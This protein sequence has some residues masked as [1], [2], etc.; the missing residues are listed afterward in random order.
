[1]TCTQ[2]MAKELERMEEQ[3]GNEGWGGEFSEDMFDEMLRWL[4]EPRKHTSV[5]L[6]LAHLIDYGRKGNGENA[7]R[8]ESAQR[9]TELRNQ[10]G[11]AQKSAADEATS[12]KGWSYRNP[13]GTTLQP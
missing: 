5:G 1:M 9:E 13:K 3:A 8:K 2:R 6:L 10:V 11:T 7:E 12:W 4:Q